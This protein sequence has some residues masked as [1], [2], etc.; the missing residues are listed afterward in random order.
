MVYWAILAFCG[1]T[2][3]DYITKQTSQESVNFFSKG[4]IVNIFYFGSHVVSVNYS[5]P[6]WEK[7]P[8]TVCIETGTA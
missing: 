7:Q 3:R 1:I 8:Q 4:H 5:T 6:P 2:G